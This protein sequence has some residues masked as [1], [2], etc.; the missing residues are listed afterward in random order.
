MISR[1]VKIEAGN[2]EYVLVPT[3][4]AL[5]I[6]EE[7]FGDILEARRVLQRFATISIVVAAGANL[8]GNAVKQMREDVFEA[9]YTNF[10]QPCAEF[11]SLLANPSGEDQAAEGDQGNP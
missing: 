6:V 5:D 3:L 8:S 7:N 9:G 2:N 4:K 11:L 10:I 1:S